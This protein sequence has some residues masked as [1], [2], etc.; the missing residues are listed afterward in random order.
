MR[1]WPLAILDQLPE[2]I[3]N[4]RRKG[5]TIDSSKIRKNLKGE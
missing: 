5:V 1:L 4:L 2:R 3:E